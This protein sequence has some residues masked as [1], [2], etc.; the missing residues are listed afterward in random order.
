MPP[1]R[2]FD[3][4]GIVGFVASFDDIFGLVEFALVA[5][6]FEPS[7]LAAVFL[8]RM[9]WTLFGIGEEDDTSA[10]DFPGVSVS[11]VRV[12]RNNICGNKAVVLTAINGCRLR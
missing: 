5:G 3:S 6:S 9:I 11:N 10:L 2:Y 8:L 4:L 7:E 1:A 12:P